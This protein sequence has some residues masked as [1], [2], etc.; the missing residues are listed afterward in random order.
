VALPVANSCRRVGLFD[1]SWV[2]SL[3]FLAPTIEHCP[4]WS[5][6]GSSVPTQ[7]SAADARA[8]RQ[9]RRRS[10]HL[11]LFRSVRLNHPRLDLLKN[12][13]ACPAFLPTP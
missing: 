4:R 2:M 7:M 8:I 5:S 3:C 9:V 10:N 12:I 1:F 11:V 13:G 6:D